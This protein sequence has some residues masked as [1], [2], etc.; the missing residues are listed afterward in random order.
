MQRNVTPEQSITMRNV[1]VVSAVD[2]DRK[3]SIPSFST[4]TSR[5]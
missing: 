5:F 1:T 3:K 4:V 2:L